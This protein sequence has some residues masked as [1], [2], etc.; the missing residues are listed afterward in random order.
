MWVELVLRCP[1]TVW[2]SPELFKVGFGAI[3]DLKIFCQGPDLTNCDRVASLRPM[4]PLLKSV[5][6][7]LVTNQS[8]VLC[9]TSRVTGGTFIKHFLHLPDRNLPFR[10]HHAASCLI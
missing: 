4:R 5:S 8:A 10:R 6:L 2:F 7:S 3:Q 9:V 1:L